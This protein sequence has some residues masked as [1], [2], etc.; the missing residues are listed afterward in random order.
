M[1]SGGDPFTRRRL[2][3]IA[4]AATTAALSA[5]AQRAPAPTATD[6][7]GVTR[8]FANFIVET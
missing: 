7:T 1:Q 5:K 6:A 2:A 4:L 8:R 3:H